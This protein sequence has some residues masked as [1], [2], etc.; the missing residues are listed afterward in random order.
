MKKIAAVIV[1]VAM[2]V[3]TGRGL[4]LQ[5]FVQGRYGHGRIQQGVVVQYRFHYE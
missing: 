4:Q 2:V 3:I 1:P 5:G